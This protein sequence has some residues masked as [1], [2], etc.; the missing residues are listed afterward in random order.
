MPSTFAFGGNVETG[1]NTYSTK[2]T[3]IDAG[4]TH[5]DNPNG[6]VNIGYSEDGDLN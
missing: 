5:E 4:G 1:G 6:G 3:H 2:I